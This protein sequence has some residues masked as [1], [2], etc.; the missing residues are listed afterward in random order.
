MKQNK[1]NVACSRAISEFYV[2]IREIIIRKRFITEGEENG[3]Q[4]NI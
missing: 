4:G 2:V 1:F 3:E